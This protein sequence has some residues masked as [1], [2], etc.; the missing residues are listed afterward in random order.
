MHASA[1]CLL[2]ALAAAAIPARAGAV[3]P[4]GA[5]PVEREVWVATRR[6][7][8]GAAAA[9]ADFR[10][11]R[12]ASRRVPARAMALPCEV[13]AGAVALRE[14]APRDVIRSDDVGPAP[15][16]MGGT[17]VRLAVVA[18]GVRVMTVAT[19]LADAGV[20][21]PVAVR[22]DHPTR[23]LRARVTG[24]AAVELEDAWR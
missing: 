5:A 20:G 22:L 14:I 7:A 4:P 2:W 9:C 1:G 8:K 17:A 6:L 3:P 24:P 13:Q 11:E 19:A 18:G 15:A 10:V 23:T 12:R 21:E 16:V